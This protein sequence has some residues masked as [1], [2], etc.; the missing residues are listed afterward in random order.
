MLRKAERLLSEWKQRKGHL[1]PVV[2]GARQ[3][4]KTFT[5][6]KFAE[7]AYESHV[8]VS[9]EADRHLVDEIDRDI[10]PQSYGGMPAVVKAR[11]EQADADRATG[12]ALDIVNQYLA[13]MT[14]DCG[15]VESV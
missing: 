2:H 12:M 9:L 14:K 10:R 3:V 7:D 4:G 1:P 8:Y 6:R 11:L 5:L 13:D 15:A